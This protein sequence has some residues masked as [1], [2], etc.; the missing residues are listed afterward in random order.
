MLFG[1]ICGLLI[2]PPI[3][4]ICNLS[5]P[6]TFESSLAADKKHRAI[7]AD[8]WRIRKMQDLPNNLLAVASDLFNGLEKGQDW[9]DLN[10]FAIISR[11][12]KDEKP[13]QVSDHE[14]KL[15]LPTAFDTRPI[16]NLS[17]RTTCYSG[18]RYRHMEP[19]REQWLPSSRNGSGHE[20]CDVSVELSLQLEAARAL[21]Q[22]VIGIAMDRRKL[23]KAFWFIAPKYL[24]QP[25]IL[26]RRFRFCNWRRAPLL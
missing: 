15:D 11:V 19:W 1:A 13:L 2:C 16:S 10:C 8:G 14:L 5:Q 6:V 23:T 17:P 7:A 4:V 22:H 12:P 21:D 25:I 26:P 20:T 18:I 24:F 3:H 9:A